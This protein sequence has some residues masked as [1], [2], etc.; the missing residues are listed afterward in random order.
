MATEQMECPDDGLS[1]GN[2]TILL[3]DDEQVIIDVARDMLEILGY[4]VIVAQDGQ[5]ASN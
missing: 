5:H 3:V 4:R 2:E 1:T